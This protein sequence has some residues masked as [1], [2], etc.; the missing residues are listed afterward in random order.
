MGSS[1]MMGSLMVLNTGSKD[2][3]KRNLGALGEEHQNQ[4]SECLLVLTQ[5]QCTGL[6]EQLARDT[7]L[8]EANV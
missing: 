2:M 7:V 3:K 4:A 6:P 8:E 5:P 1:Y